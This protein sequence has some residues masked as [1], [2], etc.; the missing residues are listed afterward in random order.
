MNYEDE[1]LLTRAQLCKRWGLKLSSIKRYERK[2]LLEPVVF[3]A[4]CK[5]YRLSDIVSIE[6]K[7]SIRFDSKPS[8]DWIEREFTS[9]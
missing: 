6:K 5:R 3:N 7:F 4:R 8:D 2:G 9:I 1:I